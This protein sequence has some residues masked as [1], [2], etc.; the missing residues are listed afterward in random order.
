M[1]SSLS[2]T[3]LGVLMLVLF[4]V[5]YYL[6][7]F[8]T[9]RALLAFVG[10]CLL[11]TVGFFGGALHAIA[12]W[13]SNLAASVTGW[14]FAAP[15]GG[16]ILVVVTGVIFIHDLMPKKTAGKR[17]G[18]AGIALAALLIAGVSG[19]PQLNSI[20]GGVQNGVTNA[21]TVVNGGH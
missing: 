8:A 9:I 1:L 13:I 16:L 12:I 15:V 10:T 17:T 11:G 14:A 21:R 19:I 20:P 2:A 3:G 18:W 6:S 7:I 4:G 5:F